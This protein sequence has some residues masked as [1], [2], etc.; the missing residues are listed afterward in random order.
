M[1]LNMLKDKIR[2]NNLINFYNFMLLKIDKKYYIKV[3]VK[4]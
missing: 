2:Q 1:K 4:Y 3:L